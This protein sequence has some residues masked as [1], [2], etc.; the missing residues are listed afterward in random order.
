MYNILYKK[1]KM[2]DQNFSKKNIE[3]IY[4]LGRRSGLFTDENFKNIDEKVFKEIIKKTKEAKEKIEETVR[5]KKEIIKE[6]RNVKN[7]EIKQGKNAKDIWEIK[8]QKEEEKKSIEEEIK[9]IY[10]DK[11]NIITDYVYK[12]LN[13][14]N[15]FKFELIC[16][17]KK[18]N[19]NDKKVWKIDNNNIISIFVMKHIQYVFKKLYKVEQ[20]NR[21]EK[22][23]QVK[24]I[25]DTKIP[26]TIFKTDI[27]SF[28]ESI[29]NEILLKKILADNLLSIELKRILK[30]L[31]IDEKGVPRGLGISPLLSELYLRNLDNSISRKDG[32]IFYSRYVDDILIISLDNNENI[33][34][35]LKKNNNLKENLSGIDLEIYNEWKKIGLSIN[36]KKTKIF[37]SKEDYNFNYLG[38]NISKCNKVQKKIKEDKEKLSEIHKKIKKINF[39]NNENIK[40]EI[41]KLLNELSSQDNDLELEQIKKAIDEF[42][43]TKKDK[44]KL[45]KELKNINKKIEDYLKKQKQ[46]KELSFKM[47]ENKI[48][49]YKEKIDRIFELYIDN[50][51]NFTHKEENILL[52]KRI[53]FITQNTI[54]TKNKRKIKIGIFYNYPL[55]DNFSSLKELDRY[56]Y[57]KADEWLNNKNI[58][59][60]VN[61]KIKKLSFK[62]GYS[63]K[64]FFS[65]IN[66]KEKDA[67]EGDKKQYIR[68]MNKIININ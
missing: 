57:E 59:T 33:E 4:Q 5:L 38:Y 48:N 25:L 2:F 51:R 6:K 23:S 68:D 17:E 21:Q 22:L 7:R 52:I 14:L 65:L 9:E 60:K 63:G 66:K 29:D 35:I 10:L 19:G 42:N 50:I 1:D 16:K 40:K 54:I 13:N 12:E 30:N 37:K 43:S 20:A 8:N 34:T 24:S 11:I 56:L 53:K 61:K 49:K 15:G 64:I 26:Y 31:L 58:S 46:N 39:D 44:E 45:E 67:Y 41:H 27:E 62:K 3:K 36:V 18:F 47:S 55:L 28:Y 32:I